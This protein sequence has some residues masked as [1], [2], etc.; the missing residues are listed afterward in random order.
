MLDNLLCTSATCASFSMPNADA[1]I[2]QE[3]VA[4]CAQFLL[5]NPPVVCSTV[6]C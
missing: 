1:C 2:S 5:G 3:S 4:S 6:G